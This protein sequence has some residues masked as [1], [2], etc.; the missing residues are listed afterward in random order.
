MYACMFVYQ[1]LCAEN[2]E[3]WIFSSQP[4]PH[5]AGC[6]SAR[7]VH[8]EPLSVSQLSRVPAPNFALLLLHNHEGLNNSSNAKVVAGTRD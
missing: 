7:K 2:G 3:D 1:L 4:P 5:S 8:Y 6:T